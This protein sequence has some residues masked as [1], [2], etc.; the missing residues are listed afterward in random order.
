MRYG[1]LLGLAIGFLLLLDVGQRIH[2]ITVG[3]E[4]EHLVKVRRDLGRLNR[5]L[6]IE[7]ETLS[8][9]DRIERIAIR[10]LRMKIP[11][12]EQ[13]VYVGGDAPSGEPAKPGPAVTVVRN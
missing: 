11:D 1:I 13:I 4:I 2:M 12:P 9:P 3:Y 7:R 10:T 6:I 8:A 5:Q